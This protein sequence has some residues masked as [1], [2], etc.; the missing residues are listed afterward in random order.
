MEKFGLSSDSTLK[1][2]AR[3]D[4]DL[5]FSSSFLGQEF[6]TDEVPELGNFFVLLAVRGSEVTQG[7]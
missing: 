1:S 5:Q 3:L 6:C 2:I 4:V 7:R